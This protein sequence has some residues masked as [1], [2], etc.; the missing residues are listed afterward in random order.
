MLALR[1]PVPPLIVARKLAQLPPDLRALGAWGRDARRSLRPA[2]LDGI[3]VEAVPWIGPPR[4]VSYG[5]WGYWMA[6]ALGRALDRLYAT[7]QFDLLHALMAHADRVLTREQLLNQVW[8]Y[9]YYGDTRT[10]DTAVKRLRARAISPSTGSRISGCRPALTCS[11]FTKRK[12]SYSAAVMSNA[13]AAGS[14]A[15]LP[16]ALDCQV[17]IS[18][19]LKV[20]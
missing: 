2:E 15:E 3:R 18:R 16:N 17:S 19:T 7:W 5:S 1:R 6:P 10:V 4:P 20:S 14:G 11:S 12:I 9:D 8:G 13:S